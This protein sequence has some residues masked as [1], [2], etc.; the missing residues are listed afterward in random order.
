MD[1]F[2]FCG[3][4]FDKKGETGTKVPASPERRIANMKLRT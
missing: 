3:D 4:D 2:L 1:G